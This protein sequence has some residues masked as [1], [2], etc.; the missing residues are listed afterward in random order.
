M[1]IRRALCYP[2]FSHVFAVMIT[3]PKEIDVINALR[4]LAA[5]MEYSAKRSK[6]NTFE[7]IGLS[8]AFVSMIKKQFRWKLLV[9]CVRESPLVAFVLYCIK[10]LRENDPLTGLSV[11]LTLNPIMME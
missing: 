5:I 1:T 9:K 3:G 10:K 6:S 11:H 2:P 7:L 4:K 8:P